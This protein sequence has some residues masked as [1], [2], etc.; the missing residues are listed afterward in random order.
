MASLATTMT[1]SGSTGGK[2]SLARTRSLATEV[3]TTRMALGGR[4]SNGG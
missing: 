3:T 1:L 2:T 4:G